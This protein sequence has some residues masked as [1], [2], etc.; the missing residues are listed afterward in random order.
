MICVVG[1]KEEESIRAKISKIGKDL[2]GEIS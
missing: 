2:K 1:I